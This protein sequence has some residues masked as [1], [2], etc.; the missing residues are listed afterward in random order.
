MVR[1]LIRAGANVNIL[2]KVSCAVEPFITNI[3]HWGKAVLHS[4]CFNLKVYCR[5]PVELI[6]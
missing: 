2:D 4:L 5:S 3:Y 1:V 6:F